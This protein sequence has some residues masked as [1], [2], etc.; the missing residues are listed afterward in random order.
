[1]LSNSLKLENALL[2]LGI[3]IESK[4]EFLPPTHHIWIKCKD[5]EDAY[6]AYKNLEKNNI[7]VNY[8]QLPY[9]IGYGLRLGTSAATLQGLTVENC[10]E[11][12]SIIFKSINGVINA[13]YVKSV[14][15]NM[16]KES[17]YAD[18]RF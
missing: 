2:E 9:E 14:I 13:N 7:H 12:A 4:K 10:K 17:K 18:Y 3:N 11:I 16:Y 15:N 5:Y 1:M 8:R 6:K